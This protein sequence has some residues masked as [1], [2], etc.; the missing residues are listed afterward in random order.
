[1]CWKKSIY[2]ASFFI[3]RDLAALKLFFKI[4]RISVIAALFAAVFGVG[5]F[6]FYPK[7]AQWRMLEEQRVLLGKE[8]LYKSVEV[9]ALR[10]RQQR[11]LTDPDFVEIIARQ[12]NRIRPNEIVFI[13]DN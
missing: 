4:V 3:S 1:M 9:A 7:Y 8:V 5:Y 13:F 6:F 10:S 2:S 11:F 12:N